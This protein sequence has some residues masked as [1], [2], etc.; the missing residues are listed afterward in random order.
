MQGKNKEA[1]VEEK[2]SHPLRRL[3]LFQLKLAVDA[4]RDLMLS[5]VSIVCTLLDFLSRRSGENSYF[6][7][8]MV[9]GRNTEKR[10]NLFGQHQQEDK[11]IDRVVSQLES[12][13]I[14]E[15]RD[16]NISKTKLKQ[17]K[18]ILNKEPQNTTQ[19]PPQDK[20]NRG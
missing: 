18:D 2:Q 8:L 9:F 1:L 5:P 19:K 15:Y 11:T 16:K 17:I 6:E 10:I 7:K 3:V 14:R 4:L 13:I 12:V 20:T